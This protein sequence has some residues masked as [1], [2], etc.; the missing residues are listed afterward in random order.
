[1]AKRTNELKGL[2]VDYVNEKIKVTKKF[3]EKAGK[4]GTPEQK[5]MVEVRKEFPDFEIE[6]EE[7]SSK[8]ESYEKLTVERMLAYVEINGEKTAVQK[9]VKDV[10]VY[11][12]ENTEKLVKGKYAT[13]KRIFLATYGKSYLDMYKEEEGKN[14][15]DK[16]TRLDEK[17]KEINKAVDSKIG[18]YLNSKI[19]KNSNVVPMSEP[20]K[21]AVNE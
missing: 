13:V 4:F 1:M 21:K 3:L 7:S 11:V 20:M 18:K 2:T 8:K 6:V 19:D 12:D 15:L 5:A 17:E 14:K 9:F 16:L 10:L